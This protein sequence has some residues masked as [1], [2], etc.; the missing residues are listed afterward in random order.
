MK[1]IDFDGTIEYSNEVE[2]SVFPP[3]KFALNQN[4]PNPFNPSTIISYNIPSNSFVK[5]E[6]FYVTGEKLTT[7]VNG[8]QETGFYNVNLNSGMLGFSSGTYFYKLTAI[9]NTSGKEFIETKKLL[10]MK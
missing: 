2:V 9:D 10:L 6:L 7:L 4:Y 8:M 5:L 3:G 1:Q